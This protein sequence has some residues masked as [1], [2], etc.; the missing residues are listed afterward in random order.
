MGAR[1]MNGYMAIVI[2]AALESGVRVY[3]TYSQN[4]LASTRLYMSAT[5]KRTE[6]K[7]DGNDQAK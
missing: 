4:K 3:Y 7:P 2:L 1:L 6:G 5:P